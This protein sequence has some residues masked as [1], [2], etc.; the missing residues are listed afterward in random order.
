LF[1][2]EFEV[3]LQYTW[4]CTLTI[5]YIQPNLIGNPWLL[6]KVFWADSATTYI[7]LYVSWLD[8][9]LVWLGLYTGRYYK[10]HKVFRSSHT[11][12]NLS[13]TSELRMPKKY[14]ETTHVLDCKL[15]WNSSFFC[16]YTNKLAFKLSQV[17]KLI[18]YIFCFAFT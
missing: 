16:N 3:M 11:K 7:F 8:F 2:I 9:L 15:K 17:S 14:F 6:E 4:I 18:M 12:I 13:Y 5:C 10:H 1:R